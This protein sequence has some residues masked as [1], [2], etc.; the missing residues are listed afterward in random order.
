[1]RSFSL[2]SVE[3]NGLSVVGFLF[4]M[5]MW[6]DCFVFLEWDFLDKM[7]GADV[8]LD[9]VVVEVIVVETVNVVKCGFLSFSSVVIWGI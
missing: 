2:K 4:G 8:L 5:V 1:M 3:I 7:V 9:V 6:V